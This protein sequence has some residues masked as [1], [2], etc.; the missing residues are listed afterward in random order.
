MKNKIICLIKSKHAVFKFFMKP[1]VPI[2][3]LQ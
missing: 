1:K 2:Y 3:A